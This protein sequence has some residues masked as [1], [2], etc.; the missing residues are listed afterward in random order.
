V[1]LVV[2]WVRSYSETALFFELPGYDV[3]VNSG[4]IL[5][6]EGWDGKTITFALDGNSYSG[7]SIS[8]WTIQFP[9]VVPTLG[10]LLA[11][12]F[13]WLVPWRFS[14]RTLLIA[15]TLVAVVLGA[16]VYATS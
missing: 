11:A 7:H 3:T 4:E 9:I 16:I 1:L 10:F 6:Y 14:L 8:D 12:A 2:L 13:P 5:V 15:T